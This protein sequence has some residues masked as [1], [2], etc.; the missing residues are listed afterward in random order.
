[1]SAVRKSPAKESKS[2]SK[3]KKKAIGLFV[4]DLHLSHKPPVYRSREP[5]WYAAMQRPLDELTTLKRKYKC[6]I[7]CAGA[8]FDRWGK[9][10]DKN[11][12][13]KL[14]TFALR[15][16][17]EMIA[18]P[19]QH[20][21]PDHNS[22]YLEDSA[23]GTLVEAEKISPLFEF[24]DGTNKM[25][26]QGYDEPDYSIT[27]FPYGV[28][29]ESEAIGRSKDITTRIAIVHEYKHCGQPHPKAPKSSYLE[30][31]D[32]CYN[33]W[34]HIIY[35]DNHQ[36]WFREEDEDGELPTVINCGTFM[37]RD[38]NE[39]DYKP[40]VT[41]LFNDGSFDFHELDTSEDIYWDDA[42]VTDTSKSSD[43][44][45]DEISI[46]E[47]QRGLQ[48]IQ[49]SAYD[50]RNSIRLAVKRTFNKHVRE[51]IEKVLSEISDE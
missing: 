21:L 3:S 15:Y 17:P 30:R 32:T 40:R 16:L 10:G 18:I 44:L 23:F 27:G 26:P 8:I 2:K 49:T 25:S 42:P 19:G 24:L 36:P 13:P 9:E 14:I 4:A 20:D 7:Y 22:K 37:I 38:K 28:L 41:I 34:S 51:V 50:F 35:G 39:R 43:I 5:D 1:M 6:P 46:G 47:L 33:G 31:S 29:L 12:C 11:V 48:A 45:L